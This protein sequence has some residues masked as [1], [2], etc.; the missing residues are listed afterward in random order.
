MSNI[1]LLELHEDCVWTLFAVEIY[2]QTRISLAISQSFFMNGC[3]LSNFLYFNID[4][5]SFR[6]KF[7]FT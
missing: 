6:M 1:I 7:Y 2:L 3:F 5:N 4:F